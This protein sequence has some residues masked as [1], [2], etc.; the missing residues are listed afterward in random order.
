VELEWTG[1]DT[2]P[3]DI[4]TYDV[5]LGTTTPPPLVSQH[6]AATTYDAVG[7]EANATYYWRVVAWDEEGLSSVGPQWVFHTYAPG[8]VDLDADVDYDD[9]VLFL[10]AFGHSRV[11]PDYHP[12]ADLDRDG[13]VSLVDYQ[14][15]RQAYGVYVGDPDA[16]LPTRPGDMNFDGRVNFGDINPFVLALSDPGGYDAAYPCG[17]IMDADVNADGQVSFGDIN[18]F[19]A[20]LSR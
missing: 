4:L 7:L 15:W 6:Q 1:G 11:Q 2:D 17:N 9:Y 10:A 20:L 5:Y 13:L 3:G 19:V 8:D 18:P 12:V 16:P 14:L